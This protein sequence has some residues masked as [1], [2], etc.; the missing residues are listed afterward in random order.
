MRPP[1][2]HDGP[3]RGEEN[4][5]L[6]FASKPE[7]TNFVLIPGFADLAAQPDLFVQRVLV[8][9]CPKSHS[10]SREM[11]LVNDRGY[12]IIHEG[13]YPTDSCGVWYWQGYVDSI[14]DCAER[15]RNYEYLAFSFSTNEYMFGA[16]YAEA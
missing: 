9:I 14:G 13:G 12:M 6:E 2:D 16:C 3:Q 4:L 10:P 5:M 15:A 11:Y 8:K 1:N 7:A